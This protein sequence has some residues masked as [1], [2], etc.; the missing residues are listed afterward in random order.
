MSTKRILA[1]VLGASAVVVLIVVG[2]MVTMG[3]K[4]ISIGENLQPTQT[5]H[6]ELAIGSARISEWDG[7]VQV[8]VPAGDFEMGIAGGAVNE[9]PVH[10]VYL[11]GYWMDQTE[12]TNEM[13]GQCVVDKACRPPERWSSATRTA[14]YD[15]PEFSDYPVIHVDWDQAK[16][17]CEWADRRLPSEAEWEKAAR[18]PSGFDYP[19]GNQPP[20]VGYLNYN[21]AVGDTTPVGAYPRG[22]SPY[23][24]YDLAGNVFEWVNDCFG[25][26][27]YRFSPTQNPLGPATCNHQHRVFRG[28]YSWQRQAH[29]SPGIAD[30]LNNLNT[31]SSAD[32]GFRCAQSAQDGDTSLPVLRGEYMGQG[33]PGGQSV[34]F[35]PE[36]FSLQ[37][38]Y[39]F[40]LHSSLYFSL[41]GKHALFAD[42][43]L[44]T[45]EIVPMSMQ[46]LPNGIWSVPQEISL[47]E[48]SEEIPWQIS[49]S[50]PPRLY[51]YTDRLPF[52]V[53]GDYP[54]EGLWFVDWLGQSWSQ[55][56]PVE[57]LKMNAGGGLVY[58]SAEIE[59]GMGGEDIYTLVIGQES[60]PEP[61]N[62]GAVINTTAE[63]HVVF[64][65]EDAGYLIFYRYDPTESAN[66]G[67]FVSF[68]DQGEGWKTPIK[69][70]DELGLRG[71]GFDVS[72]SPDGKFL[73]ILD[74][75]VGVYW[76]EAS[77]LA[78]LN[79]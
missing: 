1:L 57:E 36:V 63:E 46:Q 65:P 77:Y 67:L 16:A 6:P 26:G 9:R 28:G 34:P 38:A 3:S 53:E 61:G 12:V 24:V 44:E 60:H 59:R 78:H 70:D 49:P 5:P 75:S 55:P 62:L 69:L 74:R 39:G 33:L 47:P 23:N 58:F 19:W 20:A 18:G 45:H 21:D 13:Y 42:Q 10:Q 64:V 56:Y 41:D 48:R 32:L 71:T 73:F 4:T 54:V 22:S 68:R 17:Y 35:T 30:R 25:S 14:Y 11:D 50:L 40:Q 27:Y 37:G 79:Q 52:D 8:F 76:V 51:A 2:I 7:M 43:S 15:N 31:A 66:R 72:A 29:E